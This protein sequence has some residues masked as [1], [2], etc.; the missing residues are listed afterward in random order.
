MPFSMAS[1]ALKAET[2]SMATGPNSE[3][4]STQDWCSAKALWHIASLVPGKHDDH[5]LRGLLGL[6]VSSSDEVPLAR[7]PLR[8]LCQA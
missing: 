7:G 8:S 2:T 1:S 4:V 3:G 5:D 6:L